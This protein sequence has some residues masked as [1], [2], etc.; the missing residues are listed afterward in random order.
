MRI[1]DLC[2]GE[3]AWTV[4]VTIEMKP[5]SPIYYRVDLCEMHRRALLESIARGMGFEIKAEG[6]K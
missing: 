3:G 1:C 5:T 4:E 6:N 2:K